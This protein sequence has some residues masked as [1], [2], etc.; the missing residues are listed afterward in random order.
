MPGNVD[1]LWEHG[2]LLVQRRY[3]HLNIRKVKRSMSK[4]LFTP[5]QY[6]L[7]GLTNAGHVPIRQPWLTLCR[8][9]ILDT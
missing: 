9:C 1:F 2:P 4:T 5:V 7:N 8:C 6:G 3:A